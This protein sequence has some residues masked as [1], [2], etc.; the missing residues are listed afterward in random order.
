MIDGEVVVID[1]NGHCSYNALQYSRPE[2]HI[3]LYAF[4]ILVHRGRNVLR[5]PIEKRRELLEAA[6]SKIQYPVLRSI[7]FDAKPADLIRAAQELKLEG[8]IAKCKGRS[9]SRASGAARGS[10]TRLFA[11]RNCHRRL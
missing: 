2:G 5:L 9:T 1:E 6:L 8:M 4:D 10:S 3:Q 11:L 7:S